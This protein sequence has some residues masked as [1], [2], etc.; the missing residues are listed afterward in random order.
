MVQIYLP[1]ELRDHIRQVQAEEELSNAELILTAIEATH[2][3][4]QVR[5]DPRPGGLFS[6]DYRPRKQPTERVVQ[7]GVR[8]L[9]TDIDQIDGLVSASHTDSRSAYI[10]AALK[11]YLAQ[12]QVPR[13]DAQ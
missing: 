4:L 7:V 3:T 11:A 9:C 12:R 5:P 2:Q 8:L 10:V 13:E 1:V 6:R